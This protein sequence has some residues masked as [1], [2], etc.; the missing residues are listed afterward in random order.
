[1][2][3]SLTQSTP[4]TSSSLILLASSHP[5]RDQRDLMIESTCPTSQKI[6]RQALPPRLDSKDTVC[7]KLKSINQS[8]STSKE[9]NT[10]STMDPWSSLPLLRAPTLRTQMSC[11]QLVSLR[12]RHLTRDSLLSPTSRLPCL[13]DPVL[14][15]TTLS[16]LASRMHLTP[17]ASPLLDMVA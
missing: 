1:M 3:L 5:F 14:S 11:S 17:L 6:S 13:Q 2:A 8:R 4:E 7:L 9:K 15:R 10:S 16:M 12:N